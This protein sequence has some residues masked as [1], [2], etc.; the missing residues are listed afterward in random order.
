VVQ[1]ED[2]LRHT[3]LHDGLTGLP[4]RALLHDRLG[5]ALL[6]AREA[7]EDL[8]VIFVDLDGFK[9]INDGYGHSVGDEVLRVTAARLRAVLRKQ[10]T[11]ARFGGDEFVVLIEQAHR[12]VRDLT[13]CSDALPAD[14]KLSMREYGSLVAHRLIAAVAEP[15]QVAGQQHRLTASAG[16]RIVGPGST[17]CLSDHVDTA[18]GVLRDAD[19]AMYE[20]KE[21]GKDRF[22]VSPA[23]PGS[24]PGDPGPTK[25]VLPS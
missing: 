7:C 22:V 11:V 17:G 25:I 1:T 20:A 9:R 14:Q 23:G 2:R 13:G 4:N 24:V 12:V 21:A 8:A 16:V 3:A 6:R 19:T 18:E 5:E 15:I 10:D